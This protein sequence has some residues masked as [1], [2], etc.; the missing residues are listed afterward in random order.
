MRILKPCLALLVASPWLVPGVYAQLGQTTVTI[1]PA[2]TY[3]D[4]SAMTPAEHVIYRSVVSGVGPYTEWA[5][6]PGTETQFIDGQQYNGT[7]FY[8][9]TTI[10]TL[11]PGIESD[12]SS[13]DDN[14]INLPGNPPPK[15]NAP[16]IVAQ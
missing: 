14:V 8:Y 12:P 6:I 11:Y 4:G 10:G 5:R 2:T 1:T 3:T 16:T 15:P 7:Y 13:W 9:A